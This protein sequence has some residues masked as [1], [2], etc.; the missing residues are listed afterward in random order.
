MKFSEQWLRAWVNPRMS[1]NELVEAITMA[2]LEV[3]E[4]EPVAGDFQGVVVGEVKAVDPHPEADK[5]SL[6]Q[7]W[8]G[9]QTLDV[10]CG[11]PNVRVGLKAPLARPGATLPG[12]MAI[13][14]TEVRGQTSNGM[15]CA[16]SELELSDAG[17]GLMELESGAEPGADLREWLQLDDMSL[18]VDLTPNRS[19]CLSVRGVARDLGALAEEPFEDLVPDPVPAVHSEIP[20]VR[21]DAAAGCPRYVGRIIRNVNVAAETPVWMK[22]RLRRSGIRSID[23]V[24]DVTN[25]VMLELGQ[26]MH[27]FDR[28][29]VQGGIVVRMAS[30]GETLTLLDGQQLTLAS[31][32]LVIADHA[33]PLAL[34]GIMGGEG[35]GV[36]GKTRDIVLESAF[37]DP[38][39]L[40]GKARE[41]GL[42]TDSSHRFERGVDWQ[43]QRAATERATSLLLAI[44]GGEP[45]EV[46]EVVNEQ[47]LPRQTTVHLREAR[48]S[49]VLGMT[50]DRTTIEEILA[51]LGLRVVH[52]YRDGWEVE[53]PSFRFDIALEVDLIEE[54]GRIYGYNRMPVTE[55][56]GRLRLRTEP[57][58]NRPLDRVRDHMV[59]LGYQE[60]ITYSFVAPERQKQLMPGAESI[61][62]ANPISADMAVMRTSL[63][64]GLLDT[65][66]H[67]QKRQQHLVRL[68][69][70]GL[71]FERKGQAIEQ[72]SMLSVVL[73]GPVASENWVNG[74]R[75]V[76]FYDAKG[77][78]ESLATMLG[79]TLRFVQERHPALHP[80]QSARIYSGDQPV[81]WIGTLH[82]AIQK[83]LD[84]NG[85]VC[86]YELSLDTV[87]SGH[88]PHFQA[89]SKFPEVRRDLAML[90]D[91]ETQWAAVEDVA[92]GAAGELLTG[93]RVFDV[94]QGEHVKEGCKS[95]ALSLFWQ[96]PERTLGD[97]EVQQLMDGVTS[98]L[99]T[100]L[101]AELRS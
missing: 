57:E 43:L 25:Y 10:V 80:G 30:E 28:A 66:S 1:S 100:R 94:Y 99:N 101:G 55:P 54:I 74:N 93:L 7:V 19:D 82:P 63:W 18:D 51:R 89:F 11:A 78:L 32:N 26:P 85:N 65:L 79:Q 9:E 60:A 88:V 40:A 86:L 5:L 37:F 3:D 38:I 73:S 46:I 69:E 29:N 90:V 98:A 8:D 52:L 77:D 76:D 31:N 67:N 14:R 84:L 39:T 15:L 72:E 49:S 83:S 4:V 21:V 34:A 36:S 58:A 96:H 62:L 81:G 70:T 71:R 23:P 48:V 56:E 44:V 41:H 68:F 45:G 13:Q 6:C 59:A 91:E 12:G 2:G 42:H 35:S 92:R 16:E 47:H 50:I 61:E 75:E 87:L 64:P 17:D 97:E 33:K 53:V 22:E 24:V 95:L 20:S 27:A